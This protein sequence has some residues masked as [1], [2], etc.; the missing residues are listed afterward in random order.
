[1]TKIMGAK[2]F[3]ACAE[4]DIREPELEHVVMY[5]WTTVV[6][7]IGQPGIIAEVDPNGALRYLETETECPG[8]IGGVELVLDVG[9]RALVG[10]VRADEEPEL[11]SGFH[12]ETRVVCEL[13]QD[14]HIEIIDVI[15]TCP[16]GAVQE[17]VTLTGKVQLRL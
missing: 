17:F 1:M 3:S 10:S 5:A 14:G 7:N 8:E 16:A 13:Q 15:I 9:G 12:I 6:G 11:R 2:L 4:Q